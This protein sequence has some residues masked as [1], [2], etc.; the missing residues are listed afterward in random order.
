VPHVGDVVEGKG[1]DGRDGIA[2]YIT[3]SPAESHREK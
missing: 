2:T 1:G 3:I